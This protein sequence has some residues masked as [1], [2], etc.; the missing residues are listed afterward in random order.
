MKDEKQQQPPLFVCGGGDG[1]TGSRGAV[2]KCGLCVC[3]ALRLGYSRHAAAE[4]L[5]VTLIKKEAGCS[6]ST[7]DVIYFNE[8]RSCCTSP[9]SPASVFILTSVSFLLEEQAS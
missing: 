5:N 2:G 4:T 3:E 9:S 8:R 1:V 7:A 6:K